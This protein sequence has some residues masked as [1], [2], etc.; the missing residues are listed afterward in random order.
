MRR[1][2]SLAVVAVI[3]AAAVAAAVPTVKQA[4]ARYRAE[5]RRV[6]LIDPGHGGADG[7]ALG[8]DGTKEKEVNLAIGRTLAAFLRVMGYDVAMT[9]EE[10]I[11]IH[12]PEAATLRQQKVSDMHNRLALYEG[13]AAVISVHQNQFPQSKYSG[14]QIFYGPQNPVSRDL[15]E[16]IRSRVIGLLQPENKR[17]LKRGDDSIFLLSRTRVPAV[18]VECGFLSNPGECALLASPHYQRQMAFAVGAGVLGF[19]G[20]NGL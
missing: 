18:I 13:A 15:A 3:C 5:N 14:A 11:S 10:D 4:D 12:S 16:G 19:F 6:I 17:E 8:A 9:R 2:F 7:G 20:A 1:S